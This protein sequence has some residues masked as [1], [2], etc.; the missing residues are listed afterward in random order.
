MLA[1]WGFSGLWLIGLWERSTA[2][3]TIKQ[4]MGNP[5]AV[6]SAYSLFD[7]QIAADLGGD[8]ACNDLK[9]RAWQRGIRLASDMVPNHVGIDGKWVIEHPDWF[10]SLDYSPFPGYSFN[11]PDLSWDQ[12]VGIHIEDHYYD[13]SDAAV[14]FK[15][16]DRWTGNARYIYHGNDGTSMPWNDTAQLNYLNPEMREAMIQ[17]I[18][19]VARQFPVI[20]F[21]AAMTLVKKHSPAV[22]PGTGQRRRIRHGPTR[23]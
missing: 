7:Y 13:R 19:H 23:A 1:G 5:E 4:R 21:D 2:S 20:R 6:A 9:Q 11:G 16:V 10:V 12:R 18:L 17:T 15:R 22:V 14:V 3:R 8:A